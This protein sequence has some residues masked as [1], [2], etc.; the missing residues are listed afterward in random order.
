M[1]ANADDYDNVIQVFYSRRET[2]LE[3]RGWSVK[4]YDN[5]KERIHAAISAMDLDDDLK[6]RR[7][8][9]EEEVAD[10]KANEFFQKNRKKR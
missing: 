6:E 2:L 3:S 1:K 8:D 5:A 9:H 10:I 7:A 4:E